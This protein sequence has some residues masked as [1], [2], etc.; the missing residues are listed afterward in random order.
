MR[1]GNAPQVTRPAARSSLLV[2]LI[3][4]LVASLVPAPGASAALSPAVT[5]GDVVQRDRYDAMWSSIVSVRPAPGPAIGRPHNDH[6]RHS[7]GGT[8]IRRDVVL[9]AAHCV[10]GEGAVVGVRTVLVGTRRL[11]TGARSFGESVPVTQIAVH[12]GWSESGDSL[13]WDF[14]LLKLA[15]PATRGTTMPLVG[16]SERA[17]WGGG[18]G[19]AGPNAFVAGW[20]M[21]ATSLAGYLEEGMRI[22]LDGGDDEDDERNP[23]AQQRELHEAATPLLPDRLCA[24]TD[25]SMKQDAREFDPRSML[26]G[27]TSDT[28][29]GT[30]S[31][32][33]GACFG[34]SGGPLV[35][36]APDGSPRQVGVVSWGPGEM[37]EPCNRISVYSRVDAARDWIDQVLGEF[38]APAAIALPDRATATDLGRAGIRV[39]WPT[40][41]GEYTS[42]RL[43]REVGLLEGLRGITGEV[44]EHIVQ[45]F[46]SIKLRVEVARAGAGTDALNVQGLAPSPAWSRTPLRFR[47]EAITASGRRVLGPSMQVTPIVD[48]RRP[49]APG[50]PRRIGALYGAPVLGWSTSTDDDCVS[51]Y[52]LEVRRGGRRGWT[53]HSS[54]PIERC[55]APPRSSSY[56]DYDEGSYEEPGWRPSRRALFELPKGTY[57]A[58]VVA[59]DRAGNRGVGRPV[60]VRVP[61]YV[62]DLALDPECRVRGANVVCTYPKDEY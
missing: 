33:K 58:R 29:K 24:S 38:D 31:D 39:T 60:R 40:I 22:P 1:G 49:S 30:E 10:T 18:S 25:S 37:L 34:D 59:L 11:G 14:A 27:G 55:V 20:G 57:F 7:C 4:A 47:I 43:H 9:T 41:T 6:A 21:A 32:R 3:L 35:V 48:S 61:R 46:R 12:P 26:C 44:P 17:L 45:R 53:E 51:A 54:V 15:R 8:L 56:I 62:E 16:A 23:F 52:V 13:A 5:N 28:T 36:R 50:A 19:L 42:L 2:V